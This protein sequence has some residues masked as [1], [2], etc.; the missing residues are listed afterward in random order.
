M[1]IPY[2][3]VNFPL[4]K[5]LNP[6]LLER[7]NQ[8]ITLDASYST[9]GLSGR[10]TDFEFHQK[11][12]KEINILT[13]W[14]MNIL[15]EVSI[16]FASK[17]SEEDT[18]HYNPHN[19]KLVN[20]WGV[21]YDKKDVLVEHNHFP[22][23]LSFVYGVKTPKGSGPLFIENKK[24]QLKEGECIF[25]LASTY[26]EVKYNNCDDRCVIAGNLIYTV[27]KLR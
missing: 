3:I 22:A 6:R 23:V 27:D 15:P 10:R 5:S 1:H 25:F 19:F 9:S 13:T 12:I 20:L 21:K 16:I 26:H 17:S 7:V 8:N 24:I 4:S 11:V 2:K 18:Y 14:I